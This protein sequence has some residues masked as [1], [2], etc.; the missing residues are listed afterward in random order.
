MSLAQKTYASVRWTGASA[1]FRAGLQVAQLAVLAR[2]LTPEDY[3]LMAMV[4][5]VL[6]FATLFADFGIN[7]AFIQKQDIS[8]NERSSLFWLNV[9]MGWVLMLLLMGASPLIAWG[10]GEARLTPLL[11]LSA[12]ILLLTALG[13]QVRMAAEKQM[14]FRPVVLLEILAALLGFGT[15]VG[16]ALANGGIYALVV[17]AM[18]SATVST[19]GAWLFVAQGWWPRLHFSWHE[20]QPHFR[21]GGA[22]VA[23][24]LVNHLVFS[25]D[26]LL[27]GRLLGAAPLGLYSV[28]RN[29]VLQV[30]FVIN[31]IVTRVGFPLLAQVQQDAA[32][33]RIVY[34]KTLNMTASINAPLHLG[35]A[36]FAPEIVDILLGTQWQEIIPLLR[37]LAI[38]GLLRSLANPVG[39]LLLG[40]GR[41]DLA[42]QWNLGLLLLIPLPLWL[43]SCEG[44]LGIAST[45]LIL[46]I[47]LFFPA[48]IF[49]IRP[50]SSITLMDYTITALRPGILALGAVGGGYGLLTWVELP[51]IARLGIG[52]SL[53]I[54][55]YVWL[56]KVAN[57]D[58]YH[59]MITI[60]DVGRRYG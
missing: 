39:S 9:I 49:L 2:L 37:I 58:F 26:L 34:L 45:L 3:G 16:I 11:L 35:I 6:S 36:F 55:F 23:D 32:R 47:I 25:L 13:Q 42:L 1:A 59:S 51:G 24:G 48:W 33:V 57:H 5:L 28:P 43:G 12:T 20:I 29:L 40:L 54:I 21:F 60:A 15:A 56:V 17:G 4:T 46:Q 14:D 19:L 30:Q 41:A 27:S 52:A 10:M 50:L 7:S 22:V 44:I 18:L 31:P 8:D 38:W 53:A